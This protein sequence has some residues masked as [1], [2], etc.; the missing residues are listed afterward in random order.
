MN[1]PESLAVVLINSH[2]THD[3][4]LPAAR[5]ASE[6]S[7]YGARVSST[8]NRHSRSHVMSFLG[9]SEP[10][11]GDPPAVKSTVLDCKR[12]RGLFRLCLEAPW[13][14]GKSGDMNYAP[15]KTVSRCT[16][17]REPAA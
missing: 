12:Q 6:G 10:F 14:G 3:F 4:P 1:L 9:H 15:A 11:W 8:S 7:R 13:L 2:I 16:R 17:T 5:A